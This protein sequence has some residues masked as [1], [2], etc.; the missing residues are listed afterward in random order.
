MVEPFEKAPLVPGKEEGSMGRDTNLANIA[1]PI[2]FQWI[3]TRW[4]CSL[5][6]V[7]TFAMERLNGIQL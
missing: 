2:Q 7:V 5:N 3:T 1:N 4:D 6:P